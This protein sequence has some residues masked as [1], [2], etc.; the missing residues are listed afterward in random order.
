MTKQEI[1]AK[2]REAVKLMN[3]SGAHWWQGD[4][5][6]VIE[7]FTAPDGTYEP[8]EVAYCSLGAIREVTG[9]PVG[10]VSDTSAK[11]AGALAA[12]LPPSR[13]ETAT[14]KMH[15]SE[16]GERSRTYDRI[17]EWNDCDGREW[18]EIVEKFEEAAELLET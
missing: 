11:V 12:V 8:R 3:D 17:V 14:P 10:D 18:Q 5:S 13:G 16:A 15:E 1:A 7:W 9:T 4:Y 6:H 2:L